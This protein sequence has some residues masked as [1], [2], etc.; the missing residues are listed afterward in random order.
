MPPRKVIPDLTYLTFDPA[1]QLIKNEALRVS[2]YAVTEFTLE[3]VMNERQ[4]YLSD[5]VEATKQFVIGH[6]PPLLL[7][8]FLKNSVMVG[9]CDALIIKKQE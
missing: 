9:V 6:V 7:E 1:A 4:M 3:D 2:N 5:Q 8:K